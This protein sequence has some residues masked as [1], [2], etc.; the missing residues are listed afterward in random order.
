MYAILIWITG[1]YVTFAQDETGCISIFSSPEGARTEEMK[2]QRARLIINIEQT[3]IINLAE[4][5]E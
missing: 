1:E 5:E 3:R 2:L 4:V